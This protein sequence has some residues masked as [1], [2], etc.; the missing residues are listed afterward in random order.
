MVKTTLSLTIIN[1]TTAFQ[2]KK[3]YLHSLFCFN[4]HRKY[5]KPFTNRY[6][7]K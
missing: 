2:V 1:V 3:H 6:P 5:S 4:Q 7:K